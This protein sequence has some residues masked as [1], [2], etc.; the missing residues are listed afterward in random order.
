MNTANQPLVSIII[1]V[2][3]AEKYLAEAIDSAIGQTWGN[4]E[5]IIVDDGSTDGSLAVAKGYENSRVKVFSQENQ[6]ASAARNKGLKEATGEYIQFLDA[7]DL[8]SA[9][10]IE[11]QMNLLETLPGYL[12]I[13]GTIHFE[14]GTDPSG[15]AIQHEWFSEGSNDP[16]DFL[17][18]LYGGSFLNPGYCG[19]VTI[20][21]WLTP[22]NIIDKAG[23][24]NEMRNPDDDG[25]FFCRVVLASNGIVYADKAINYYRKFSDNSNTLSGQRH[26]AALRNILK[27]TDLKAANLLAHTGKP[28]AK[29]VMSRLYHENAYSFYP[30]FVDLSR[31]AERK[32]KALA[33]GFKYNPYHHGFPLRLSKIIGWKAVRYL[34]YLKNK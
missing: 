1:A 12:A 3:N 6:G 21:S 22:K 18:K 7:D 2:Y 33:P 13:C 27:S 9:N 16:A 19:M 4:K 17:V 26:Y 20:H 11:A 10:K 25:E 14:N 28:E 34:Q 32:A 23:L 24:F 29:L 15:L 30:K 8:L 31:E 5:I